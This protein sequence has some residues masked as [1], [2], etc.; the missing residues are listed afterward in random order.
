MPL[1]EV[2]ARL[3]AA[4]QSSDWR[5]MLKLEV[6]LEELL[7]VASDDVRRNVTLL[8]FVTAHKK[9]LNTTGNT[10]HAR[11]VVTLE[12]RRVD[13]LGKMQRFRDQVKSP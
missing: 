7:D 12:A 8:T 6:R 13:L 5:A 9:G 11:S 3:G 2:D 4:A 10:E 1:H